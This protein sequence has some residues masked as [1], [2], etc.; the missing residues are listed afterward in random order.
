MLRA[1]VFGCMAYHAD[2]WPNIKEGSTIYYAT[3]YCWR[4]KLWRGILRSRLVIDSFTSRN[5][6]GYYFKNVTIANPI[7]GG[8]IYK[9]ILNNFLNVA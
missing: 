1:M 9:E 6:N 8:F 4:L 2:I 5:K 7:Y 3:N